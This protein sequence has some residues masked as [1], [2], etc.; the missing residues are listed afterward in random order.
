M[1]MNNRRLFLTVLEVNIQDPA[2]SG[3]IVWWEQPSSLL[4]IVSFSFYWVRIQWRAEQE[5]KLSDDSAC[6][7]A[8]LLQSCPTLCNPMDYSPP[9]SSV[10][11]IL[12]AK[13]VEWLAMLLS[14]GSSWP[15]D[16]TQVTCVSD[17]AGWFFTTK[18]WGSP[19]WLLQGYWSHP[20]DS[21]LMMSSNPNHLPKATPHNTIALRR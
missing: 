21:T 4:Q 5:S 16:K 2:A 3:F 11:G 7:C 14:R 19:Q 13:I 8:K 9:D 15:R 12:Q 18:H 20:G 10:H 6:M 1:L 17:T